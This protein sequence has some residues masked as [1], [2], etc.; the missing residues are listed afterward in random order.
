MANQRWNKSFNIASIAVGILGLTSI[1]LLVMGK[2][3]I[4]L[5]LLATTISG[6]FGYLAGAGA[7]K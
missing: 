6:V 5:G 2:T 1:Y 3:D 7:N 4:G